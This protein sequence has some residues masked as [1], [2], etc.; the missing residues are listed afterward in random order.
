MPYCFDTLL[1]LLTFWGEPK[2]FFFFFFFVKFIYFFFFLRVKNKIPLPLTKKIIKYDK[3]I[4]KKK[5]VLSYLKK[6]ID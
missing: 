5:N 6:K 3:N 4:F 2:I 1:S